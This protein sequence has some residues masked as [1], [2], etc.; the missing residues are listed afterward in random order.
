MK[1]KKRILEARL[2]ALEHVIGDLMG[3]LISH[4][5]AETYVQLQQD[6]KARVGK[7]TL[8]GPNATQADLLKTILN[9]EPSRVPVQQ[10]KKPGPKKGTPRPK[11]APANGIEQPAN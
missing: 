7:A 6:W 8:L 4:F 2:N 9:A 5:G 11:Q 1:M 10:K 3:V